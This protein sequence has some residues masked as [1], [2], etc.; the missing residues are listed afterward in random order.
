MKYKLPRQIL[1]PEV[2]ALISRIVRKQRIAV[3]R[4]NKTHL[5]EISE[6][7]RAI[8][9]SGL[10]KYLVCRKLPDGLGHGIFLHPEAEPL[11]KGR[12]IAPYSGE[13][14]F[15]GQNIPD[16]SAYAFAPLCDIQMTKKEQAL[17]DPKNRYHPKRLYSLNLDAIKKGNFTRFI[18]HSEKPNINAEF[19]RI[20]ANTC[21]LTPSPLEVVYVAN[22]IIRPGEQLLVCYEGEDKSYWGPLD[23]KPVPITSKTFMLSPSL[24]IVKTDK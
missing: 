20:P 19:F 14:T 15:V 18:N 5:K 7:S 16:E 4:A 24:K 10:P 17:F 9:K 13:V 23:I 12:I 8:A 22:K 6:V 3:V 21:G 1:T 2:S 11:A